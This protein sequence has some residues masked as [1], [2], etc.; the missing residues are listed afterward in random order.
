MLGRK[1]KIGMMKVRLHNMQNNG[2]NDNS[3]G[4]IKKLTRQ[5]RNMAK[6][7]GEN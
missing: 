7:E 3:P 4:V 5:L 6:F 1:A 2:R